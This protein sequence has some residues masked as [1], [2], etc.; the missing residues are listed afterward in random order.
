VRV[1]IAGLKERRD[2]LKK[3][4]AKA[5]K[6]IEQRMGGGKLEQVD[7]PGVPVPEPVP[8]KKS[9]NEAHH[10]EFQNSRRTRLERLG[11]P[12]VDDK[13]NAIAFV[14]ASLSRIR[15][16]CADDEELWLLFD[17]YFAEPKPAQYDPPYPFNAFA[18]EKWWK[19]LLEQ[20]VRGQPHQRPA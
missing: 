14:N 17:A 19:Y 5:E 11:V 15:A 1:T 2:W 3:E 7:L 6:E 8:R 4:L 10:D 13:P 18:S 9:A 16:A 20:V 12:F